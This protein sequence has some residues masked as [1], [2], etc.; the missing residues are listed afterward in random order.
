MS[1]GTTLADAADPEFGR[2]ATVRE[3]ALALPMRRAAAVL[4]GGIAIMAL[5]GTLQRLGAAPD[6]FDV[7]GEGKPP[8]AWS[9]LVL[10]VAAA[11]AWLVGTVPSERP[12]RRR[13]QA[14]AA[15]LAFMGAD[16]A[17]TLHEHLSK[18][19]GGVGWLT[20]YAPVAA[21]GGVMW[22]AVLARLWPLRRERSLM[23]L[24]AAAWCI[25]QLIEKFESNPQ[26]GR[27][28]GYGS[29]SLIEEILEVTGSALFALALL[30]ALQKLYRR[31]SPSDPA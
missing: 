23:I 7:D 15:F 29:L 26:V 11:A 16:E 25:S 22:L 27:V 9:A 6:L 8:A 12:V 20:L 21:V 3:F 5:L 28:E 19:S 17:L 14:L 31:P 10:L 24:G 2:I 4:F 1:G 18:A 30:G 13:Y